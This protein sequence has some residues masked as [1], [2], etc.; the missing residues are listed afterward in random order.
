MVMQISYA[1]KFIETFLSEMI[2]IGILVTLL[3][4]HNMKYI[5]IYS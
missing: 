5:L 3:K 4:S 1:N 2:Q